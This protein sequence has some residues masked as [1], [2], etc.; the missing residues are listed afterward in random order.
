[1]VIEKDRKEIKFMIEDI[2][3][4]YKNI[5]NNITAEEYIDDFREAFNTIKDNNL[6]TN[7]LKELYYEFVIHTFKQTS[8]E[9]FLVNQL[10]DIEE[11]LMLKFNN[12]QKEQLKIYDYLHNEMSEIQGFTSFVYGFCIANELNKT[13]DNFLKD[14]KILNEII[15]KLK[16]LS[17]KGGEDIND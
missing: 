10:A 2:K 6:N 8:A 7:F 9:K 14:D 11:L 5:K 17:I 4:D 12:T 13:S 16:T 1:M 15:N 3:K